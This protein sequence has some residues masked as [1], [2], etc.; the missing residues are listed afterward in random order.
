[1]TIRNSTISGNRAAEGGG[2]VLNDSGGT[3]MIVNSTISGNMADE[4]GAIANIGLFGENASVQL[5]YSTIVGNSAQ[6][7]GGAIFNFALG[8]PTTVTLAGSV[9]G[10]SVQGGDCVS[11]HGASVVDGGYNVIEDNSCGF[12][13]GMDPKIGPLQDNGGPTETHALLAGSPLLDR[14]PSGSNDCGALVSEDQRGAARPQP[15]NGACDIG[16]FELEQ[17]DP[18]LTP[19]PTVTPTAGPSPTPSRT[20]TRGPSPTPSQTA[21]AGPSPTASATQLPTPLPTP[22]AYYFLPAVLE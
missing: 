14:I 6:Q 7:M 5:R 16:A 9:V 18:G 17:D 15:V 10:D 8:A 22:V 20:P 1:L 12:Q 2:G 19:S 4:G 11:D 21:T 3:I 13:G